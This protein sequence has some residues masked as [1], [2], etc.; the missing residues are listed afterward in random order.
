MELTKQRIRPHDFLKDILDN[1]SR[2]GR[3]K[4]LQ[5]ELKLAH[6]LTAIFV[7]KDL[8]R[9]AINN[10]LTNAIKYNNPHGKVTLSAE[11]TQDIFEIRV[12][13]TGIGITSEDQAHIFEKFFR[14]DDGEVRKQTGH[15]LGLSLAKQIIQLHHGEL[16]LESKPG[17]G[18]TFFI[19]LN[20]ILISK[21]SIQ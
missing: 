11:E 18:T 6:E 16:I 19:K 5:F 9:I 10:L 1:V 4:D 14:S 3:T 21:Q 20:K 13:D 8:L 17:E 7:D 12:E 2:S 15:G